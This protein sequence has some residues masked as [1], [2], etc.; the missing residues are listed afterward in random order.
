MAINNKQVLGHPS[1]KIGNLVYRDYKGRNTASIRPKKYKQ[2]KSE[3]LKSERSLFARRIYLC[4]MLNQSPMLNHLWSVSKSPGSYPFH[5][6]FKHCYTYVKS[7]YI[8]SNISLLPDK[9][10]QGEF[11]NFRIDENSFSLEFKPKKDVCDVFQPPYVFIAFIY[12]YSPVDENA[13]DKEAYVLLEEEARGIE[14]VKNEP[15]TH[16]F[17]IG[18]SNFDIIN[19]FNKIFVAPAFVGKKSNNKSVWVKSM[20][21]FIKGKQ[22]PPSKS[23]PEVKKDSDEPYRTFIIKTK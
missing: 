8:S 2:T 22:E 19:K 7:D 14:L 17:R 9:K 11:L 13:A 6:I 20:G 10:Y 1:G 15:V 5:K 23:N 3:K 12:M 18:K 16:N 4:K 21:Y